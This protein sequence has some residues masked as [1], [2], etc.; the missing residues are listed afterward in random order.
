MHLAT[1]H[2][3]MIDFVVMRTYQSKYCLDVQVMRGANCWTDHYLVRA[4]LRVMLPWTAVAAKHPL[5][6]AMHK[7]AKPELSDSYVQSLE[8]RLSGWSL[9]PGSTVKEYWNHLQS[10]VTSSAEESIK[11]GVCSNPEWFKEYVDVLKPLIEG[12]N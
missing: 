10:C 7:F 5:P 1:K 8:Q 3:H 11:R 9:P 12:K 2:C 6:F 4:R